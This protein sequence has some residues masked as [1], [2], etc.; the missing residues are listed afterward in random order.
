MISK[1]LVNLELE[2]KDKV[3]IINELGELAYS[4]GKIE[5]KKNYIEAVLKREN[6]F[7]TA[8]G[9]LIAIPHGK[10]NTV[11]TPFVAFGRTAENVDWDENGQQ[12]VRMV[13]LLGIPE[14]NSGDVH[15]RVLANISRNLMDDEFRNKLLTAESID[16]VSTILN[17]VAI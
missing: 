11:R 13:F 14:V 7:S 17:A 16:E 1:E 5:S 12:S 8:F 4:L 9:D 10:S 6:E 3:G 2:A 15:L